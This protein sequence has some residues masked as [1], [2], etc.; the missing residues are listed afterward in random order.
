MQK[1]GCSLYL[2]YRANTLIFLPLENEIWRKIPITYFML[3]KVCH[4]Y[5]ILT[6]SEEKY[7]LGLC[8]FWDLPRKC[9]DMTQFKTKGACFALQFFYPPVQSKVLVMKTIIRQAVY[10]LPQRLDTTLFPSKIN[11][12]L[13]S[14]SV[15][16]FWLHLGLFVCFSFVGFFNWKSLLVS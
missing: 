14:T 2:K 16:G 4:L 3:S 5:Q 6:E 8:S 15:K 7:R 10:Y 13:R 1:S 9:L 11:P 12:L